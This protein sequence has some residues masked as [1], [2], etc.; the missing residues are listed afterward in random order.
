MT[1]FNKLAERP[2][3]TTAELIALINQRREDWWPEDFQLTIDRSGEHDWVAVTQTASE[4]ADGKRRADL[5]QSVARVVAQLRLR[6][7]WIGH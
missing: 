2:K 7:A 1:S 6:N 5:V 3:K 4:S